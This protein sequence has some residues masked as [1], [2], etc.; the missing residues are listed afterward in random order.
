MWRDLTGSEERKPVTVSFWRIVCPWRDPRATAP[1]PERVAEI[2][3][4]TKLPVMKAIAVA[5]PDDVAF[6][7]AFAASADRILFDAKADAAASL[8]GGN[9]VAFDCRALKGFAA[10]F[11][12]S[13]GLTPDTVGEAIR[14]TGADLV[15]VSSGVERAPGVKDPDR[16]RAF[17]SR[18]GFTSVKIPTSTRLIFSY[19]AGAPFGVDVGWEGMLDIEAGKLPGKPRS[20]MNDRETMK[21]SASDFVTYYERA[22]KGRYFG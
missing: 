21:C 17:V 1:S 14:M 15:D 3:A 10:P 2:K 7:R 18:A 22:L 5:T 20:P 8:P 4:R 13:G 9:G 6:A 16:V 19:L 11:A 12:L